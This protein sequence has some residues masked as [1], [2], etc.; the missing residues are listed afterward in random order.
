MAARVLALSGIPWHHELVWESLVW[1][2]VAA[3]SLLLGTLLAI[4]RR[5]PPRLLGVVLGFGAGAL[6]A[7]VSLDLVAGGY[8]EAGALAVAAGL[9]L[10][11]LAYYGANRAVDRW[12]ARS[13]GNAAGAPLALGALL[14]GI[15]EQ[16]VLGI[17]LAAGG[18][19][20][21]ALLV[22]IFVSNLPESIGSSA[23]MLAA[24]R[25]RNRVIGLWMLV[26]AVC[27]AATV[28]GF[29][30]ADVIGAAA[31]AGVNGFAAGAL[32]VMLTNSMIPEAREKAGNLSGLAAVVGFAV[33]AALMLLD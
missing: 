16:A 32:L 2:A 24:G 20:S 27:A 9:S 6:I 23:D 33:A 3:S 4:A 8:Q 11:A 15:P 17:G 26:T 30:V 7:S 12:T 28:A 19:V 21:V 1:G 22:A 25:R 13:G 10:G 5:W 14:D 29:A 18:G 31:Q